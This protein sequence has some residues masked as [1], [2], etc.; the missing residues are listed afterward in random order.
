MLKI[1][2]STIFAM[3]LSIC[4]Q[5]Q[6]KIYKL[7]KHQA[8]ADINPAI[9]YIDTTQTQES[10]RSLFEPVKGEY[11]V[12]VFVAAYQGRSY[13]GSRKDFHDLLILKTDKSRKI[14]NAFQYTL[15]WAE[16][17][18]AWDLYRSGGNGL[19]L[20]NKLRVDRLLFRRVDYYR[21][22]GQILV[23]KGYIAF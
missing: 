6:T 21:E 1:I 16:M 17:P 8:R 11:H 14:L 15:E 13:N 3:S 7:V 19:T 2:L 10:R 9:Q 5:A 18:F 4:L 20:A 12:Y 23:D 22:E